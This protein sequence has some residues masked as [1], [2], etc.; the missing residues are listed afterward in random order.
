MSDIESDLPY[1]GE[2][3]SV[4]EVI[5]LEGDIADV[6]GE[7]MVLD[8]KISELCTVLELIC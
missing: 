3:A 4:D 8:R 6:D 5:D 7:V 1:W 2:A